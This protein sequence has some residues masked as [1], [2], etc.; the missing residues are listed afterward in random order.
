[1]TRATLLATFDVKNLKHTIKT[2]LIEIARVYK[3]GSPTDDALKRIGNIEAVFKASGIFNSAGNAPP[4][5][6]G[7]IGVLHGIEEYFAAYHEDLKTDVEDELN[8]ML[9]DGLIKLTDTAE[10]AN[11]GSPWKK[12]H[13]G[14]ALFCGMSWLFACIQK[15]EPPKSQADPMDETVVERDKMHEASRKAKLQVFLVVRSLLGILVTLNLKVK[16][17]NTWAS[18]VFHPVVWGT[19]HGN[20]WKGLFGQRLGSFENGLS[21]AV[22]LLLFTRPEQFRNYPLNIVKHNGVYQQPGIISD[23]YIDG[24]SM[25][26]QTE[27]KN[28]DGSTNKNTVPFDVYFANEK[29]IRIEDNGIL[30][31]TVEQDDTSLSIRR[32]LK[33]YME[34]KVPGVADIRSLLEDRGA[35]VLTSRKHSLPREPANVSI[36]SP[37]DAG[38]NDDETFAAEHA[39][40][41]STQGKKTTSS[42]QLRP[43]HEENLPEIGKPTRMTASRGA[44]DQPYTI[45][46]VARRK[47][48]LLVP[49]RGNKEV[50]K[51]SKPEHDIVPD[52]Q[53]NSNP[54]AP[55]P[56]GKTKTAGPHHN[57]DH[58]SRTSRVNQ[59]SAI[60][61]ESTGS[62]TS[63]PGDDEPDVEQQGQYNDIVAAQV[64]SPGS[65]LHG[66]PAEETMTST[67]RKSQRTYAKVTETKKITKDKQRSQ[68]RDEESKDVESELASVRS[69]RPRETEPLPVNEQWQNLKS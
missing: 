31:V 56:P 25:T 66:K 8:Y 68:E 49:S 40:H 12:K 14:D 63:I 61:R 27:K 37:P 34:L 22:D 43:E 23:L 2:C 28:L 69:E 51:A 17:P 7:M 54:D 24:G 44:M 4:V 29:P 62:L 52:S 50:A 20:S 13:L 67:A 41:H 30:T 42:K 33:V 60:S 32:P 11:Q 18:D 53:A 36:K 35:K 1:M 10:T 45:S 48:P 64:P 5:A 15:L 58:D 16:T 57:L 55:I 65:R 39:G 21:R 6:S 26:W 46:Q 38:P 9:M 19:Q 59:P 47:Q 3:A